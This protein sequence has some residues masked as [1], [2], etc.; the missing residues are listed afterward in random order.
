MSGLLAF[1][2]L[3]A[4]LPISR[5]RSSAG[6][7]ETRAAPFSSQSARSCPQ[8]FEGLVFKLW[9]IARARMP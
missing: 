8:I 6:K 7:P 1:L 4:L 5:F 9:H 3:L 2:W